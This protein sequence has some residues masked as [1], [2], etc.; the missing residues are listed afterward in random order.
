[1]SG[2]QH[3]PGPWMVDPNWGPTEKFPDW[4]A[5]RLGSES[6]LSVSGHVGAANARLIAA[7][8]DMLEALQDIVS[9]ARMML[10]SP[11]MKGLHSYA[12]EV[13]RVAEAA[14]A[15]AECRS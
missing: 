1:M 9:G 8:P 11:V 7:A 15:K 14:I 6:Y 3:A 5:V 4:A 13:K 2:T 10:D 12:A